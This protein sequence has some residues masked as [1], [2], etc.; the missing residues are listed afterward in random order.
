M[1]FAGLRIARVQVGAKMCQRT[2]RQVGNEGCSRSV[3]AAAPC[4]QK[5]EGVLVPYALD[6]LMAP[7]LSGFQLALVFPC[8]QVSLEWLLTIVS[9]FGTWGAFAYTQMDHPILLQ[10]ASI[11]GHWGLSFVVASAAPLV[12]V[13]LTPPRTNVWNP[14]ALLATTLTATLIFG[15]VRLSAPV[16]DTAQLNIVGLAAKP[17]DLL[18]VIAV[19]KG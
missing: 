15:A 2:S 3:Q 16:G 7:R 12:A 11:T 8:A 6:R 13:L 19:N 17:A 4:R 18:P 10:I 5:R 9:P 1:Q 14:A